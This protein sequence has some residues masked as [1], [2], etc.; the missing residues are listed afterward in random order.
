MILPMEGTSPRGG[1]PGKPT[2]FLNGPF[3]EREPT[4]SP[5]GRWI[6]YRP[7]S[8]A[9]TKLRWRPFLPGP[10]REVANLDRWWH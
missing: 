5:D 2:V 6:A 10:R 3:N 7:T 1:K 9:G 8:Q 4:F